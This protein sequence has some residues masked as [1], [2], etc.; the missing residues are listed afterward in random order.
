[1]TYQDFK[2]RQF[3]AQARAAIE[4]GHTVEAS[5]EVRGKQSCA[6]LHTGDD[7]IVTL[8]ANGWGNA[9][10]LRGLIDQHE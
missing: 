1:M 5:F 6:R 9:M 2:D 10:Y 7:T 3:L 8:Q 4:A